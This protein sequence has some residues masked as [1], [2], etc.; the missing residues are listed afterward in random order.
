MKLDPKV[1]KILNACIL[2]FVAWAI[3][4]V[5]R[6]STQLSTV[7]VILLPDGVEHVDKTFLK[8]GEADKAA[9]YQLRVRST[10][11]GWLDL[12]TFANTPI[13]TGI[14]FKPSD[15]YPTRTIQ[16]VQLLDHDKIE[17][18]ILDQGPIENKQY[19][20]S[21]YQFKIESEFSIEAGL[22]WFFATPVGI[23]ILVGIGIA[24]LIRVV[25]YI[26]F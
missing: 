14:D 11:E 4:G 23:A 15:T 20:G 1:N 16:E 24:V 13:G 10:K 2:G 8:I 3:V 17:S 6:N 18:D 25:P 12:G 7:S 22:H 21:N 9:D 26:S 19:T 5:F